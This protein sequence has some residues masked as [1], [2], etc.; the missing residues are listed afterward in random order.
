VQKHIALTNHQ[1]NPQSVVISKK[2]WD[3][4]SADEKK[5]L[6]DAANRAK[7]QREQARAVAAG[8]WTT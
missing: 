1:Y 2:F 4:L 7:F 5:I 6:Q 8:I 3:T